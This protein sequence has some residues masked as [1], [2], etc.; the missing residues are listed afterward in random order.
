MADVR[1]DGLDRVLRKVRTLEQ[2]KGAKRGL[3]AAALHIKAMTAK[4]PPESE[5]N[6]PNARG[7]WYERGYG[8][9][10]ISAAGVEGGK[11]T[12]ETLGRKW[13]SK[14][15]KN[16]LAAIIGNNVSYGPFVQG[17]EQARFHKRRGWKT[18]KEVAEDEA[19]TVLNLIKK[20]VDKELA[21]G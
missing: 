10:W 2:M 4:Y 16:G 9:K 21:K 1:I 12:S 20:T 19:E 14:A 18:T 17:D 3:K 15:A 5:A 6:R 7:R 8:P 11:R 13:T